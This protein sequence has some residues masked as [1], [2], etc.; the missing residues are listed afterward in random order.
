MHILVP[1]RLSAWESFY[2]SRGSCSVKTVSQCLNLLKGASPCHFEMAKSKNT[3]PDNQSTPSLAFSRP[4][5]IDNFAYGP[6]RGTI[7]LFF[8]T[9]SLPL[10]SY[11]L[12]HVSYMGAVW[13]RGCF[14]YVAQSESS[15]VFAPSLFSPGLGLV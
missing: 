5:P 6:D 4:Q 9:H 7:L 3:L 12:T 2:F 10:T 13:G 15:P 1:Q 14:P 8:S 11:S